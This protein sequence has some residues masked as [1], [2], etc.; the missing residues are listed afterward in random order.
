MRVFVVDSGTYGSHIEGVF[1]DEASAQGVA[2][3]IPDAAVRAW[4]VVRSL[5]ASLSAYGPIGADAGAEDAVVGEVPDVLFLVMTG[6]WSDFRLDAVVADEAVA[7]ALATSWGPTAAI[8]RVELGKLHAETD[9]WIARLSLGTGDLI[10][11]QRGAP[12]DSAGEVVAASGIRILRRA[13]ASRVGVLP[14]ETVFAWGRTEVD[15]TKRARDFRASYL[16][17]PGAEARSLIGVRPTEGM[18]E[19]ER[20]AGCLHRAMEGARTALSGLVVPEDRSPG[21][22]ELA[23]VLASTS[24]LAGALAALLDALDRALGNEGAQPWLSRVSWTEVRELLSR[25]FARS[26]GWSARLV[27]FYGALNDLDNALLRRQVPKSFVWRETVELWTSLIYLGGTHASGGLPS[28]LE[29]SAVLP[30][31]RSGPRASSPY[32][33]DREDI[34]GLDELARRCSHL[35][36]AGDAEVDEL[37]CRSWCDQADGWLTVP[38]HAVPAAEPMLATLVREAPVPEPRVIDRLRKIAALPGL[39][40][41][42]R[43]SVAA[44]LSGATLE[45]R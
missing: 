28:R 30:E 44:W 24:T 21:R 26:A 9:G 32:P 27:T 13:W 29:R 1:R 2:D 14:D 38:P 45:P 6:E 20:L 34:T 12:A 10:A 19:L 40:E 37:A 25:R 36:M 16:A 15:A 35:A 5:P 39:S 42:L 11:A 4:L 18:T 33:W 8:D 31:R 17:S 23:A 41:A 3:A 7:R 43:R 22:G